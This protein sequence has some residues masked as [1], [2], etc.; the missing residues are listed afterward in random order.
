MRTLCLERTDLG[1][2]VEGEIEVLE[3]LHVV[4]VLHLADDVVL[5][6]EY[7]EAAAVAAEGLV[8]RLE[9]LLQIFGMIAKRRRLSE[10]RR[11]C[12]AI[13]AFPADNTDRRA[14]PIGSKQPWNN[15]AASWS[16]IS[17]G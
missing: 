11:S 8:D 1:D 7:L 4:Q 15:T 6:V 5:E 14:I 12:L 17:C 13:E 2:V 3:L 9:L 16:Y 10:D